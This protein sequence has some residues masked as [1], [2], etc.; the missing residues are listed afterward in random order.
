MKAAY[1]IILSPCDF[2]YFVTVPDFNINTQGENLTNAIE[3]ARDAISLYGITQEDLGNPIPESSSVVPPHEENEICTF[4][5]VDFSAYRKS[6]DNRA[7]K[8]TLS[9]PSWLNVAAEKAGINFSRVLQDA[10]MKQLNIT[11]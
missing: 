1:P 8:K 6:I 10:L 11:Q 5:D 2:G 7:V 3:M 9:I 4:V